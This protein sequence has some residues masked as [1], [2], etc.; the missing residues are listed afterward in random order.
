MKLLYNDIQ[1]YVSVKYAK[2]NELGLKICGTH[3][4]HPTQ[5]NK[6]P[7]YLLFMKSIPKLEEVNN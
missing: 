1:N 2:T 6:F 3:L 4:K 5:K 7:K